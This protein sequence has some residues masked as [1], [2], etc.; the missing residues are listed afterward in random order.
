LHHK[1]LLNKAVQTAY[2][3]VICIKSKLISEVI[4]MTNSS[5]VINGVIFYRRI[6]VTLT[7]LIIFPFALS[8]INLTFA[9][10]WKLHFFPA[11]IILAALVFGAAGG[12]VAG[13]AGSV[14]SALSL[15]NPYLIAG[16]AL[17]G[18]LTGIFYKKTN[19]IILAVFLAFVCELPW[20]IVTDYYFMRLSAE[21]IAKLVL[22][23]FL[24]DVFWAALIQ[25]INKPLRKF[26]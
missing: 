9:Q 21:F 13:I 15:G 8:T 25:A 12:L 18:L 16:N 5:T 6:A 22:V 14:Y 23:L 11:A 10:S 3:D 24:A 2:N 26:L 19:K 17:F 1:N 4:N 20:L 7:L